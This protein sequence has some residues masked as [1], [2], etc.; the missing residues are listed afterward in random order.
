MRPIAR[1]RVELLVA[2]I[3]QPIVGLLGV[4]LALGAGADVVGSLGPFAVIVVL[5]VGVQ[6]A[7][8][9]RWIQR[10]AGSADGAPPDV[11]VEETS[12]TVRRSV[13]APG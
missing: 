1:L 9:L 7:T 12:G 10:T 11:P 4:A 6:A 13:V 2:G 3:G 8:G 5:L